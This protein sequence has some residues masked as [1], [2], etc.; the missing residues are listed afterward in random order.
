MVWSSTFSKRGSKLLNNKKKLS[1]LIFN[2]QNIKT[3]SKDVGLRNVIG[4]G[5]EN[6]VVNI[7]I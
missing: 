3:N 1:G 4:Q 2:F 6:I 5:E 7:Q